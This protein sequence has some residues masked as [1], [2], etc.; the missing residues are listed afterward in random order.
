MES[1][2]GVGECARGEAC[3]VLA[4]ENDYLSYRNSHMRVTSEWQERP[5]RD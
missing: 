2:P 4:L 5:S 1:Q 3:E